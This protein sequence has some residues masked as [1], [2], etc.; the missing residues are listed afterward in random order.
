MFVF[1]VYG[2]IFYRAWFSA[3]VICSFVLLL[4]WAAVWL[5]SCFGLVV[6]LLCVCVFWCC[7]ACGLHFLML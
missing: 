1:V 5:P 4:F 3:S 6:V 7:V 2:W